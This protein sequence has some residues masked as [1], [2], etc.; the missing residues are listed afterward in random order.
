LGANERTHVLRV[1]NS[2]NRKRL[3]QLSPLETPLNLLLPFI[4]WTNQGQNLFCSLVAQIGMMK[5]KFL[6][7]FWCEFLEGWP[8]VGLLRF[9]ASGLL[10]LLH[11]TD[12]DCVVSTVA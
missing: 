5:Q 1:T 11:S 6:S 3:P 2:V 8:F 7:F 9:R 10:H 12:K 4:G